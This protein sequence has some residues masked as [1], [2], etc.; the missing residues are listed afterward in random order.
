MNFKKKRIERSVREFRDLIQNI[1]SANSQLYQ[2]RIEK[3]V[4]FI[5]QDE[6]MQWLIQPFLEIELD[7]EDH[8]KKNKGGWTELSLPQSKDDEIAFTLSLLVA[9]VENDFDM[10]NWA[11]QNF[12]KKSVSEGI[13][14]LNQQLLRPTFKEIFNRLDDLMEDVVEDKNEIDAANLTIIKVGNINATNSNV[15]VGQ[16]NKQKVQI[17]LKDEIVK[18]LLEKGIEFKKIE[19]ISSDL[20]NFIEEAQ[21]D[22]PDEGKLKKFFKPIFDVGKQVAANVITGVFQKPEVIAAISGYVSSG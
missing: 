9:S 14:E 17:G 4:T 15:A 5:K 11:F 3:L 2:D 21:K 16:N 6:V 13:Y 20:D 1:L 7:Y 18:E 8:V 22:N 19:S 12:N 10:K